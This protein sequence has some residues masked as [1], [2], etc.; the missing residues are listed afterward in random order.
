MA[1]QAAPPPPLS[2]GTS[3]EGPPP[4]GK[5]LLGLARDLLIF[6]L[7]FLVVSTVVGR[8]RAPDLEGEAPP[9]TLISTDGERVELA[10]L[11]GKVV[12]LNFW[13]TWCPACRAEIPAIS[14][15]HDTHGDQVEVLAVSI[16]ASDRAVP[17]Y[18]EQHNLKYPIAFDV[19]RRIATQFEVEG[20]PTQVL[21]D[22]N[23]VIVYRG[24]DTPDVSVYL[25]GS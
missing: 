1:E 7:L 2:S 23:G 21:I 19:S 11:R 15:L 16:N 17:A 3:P 25:A 5:R 10:D 14:K 18:V 13:A 8:L 12:V 6:G 22:K 24:S 9:L 4:L 20:T